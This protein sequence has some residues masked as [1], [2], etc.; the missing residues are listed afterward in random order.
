M[1]LPVRRRHAHAPLSSS[2][3]CAERMEDSLAADTVA[4]GRW[5]GWHEADDDRRL[6]RAASSADCGSACL[7]DYSC[8]AYTFNGRCTA[9]RLYLRLATSELAGAGEP[10]QMEDCRDRDRCSCHRFCRRPRER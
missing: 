2:S 9:G 5:T 1:H 4:S 3:R 10:P 8:S 6:A 7:G